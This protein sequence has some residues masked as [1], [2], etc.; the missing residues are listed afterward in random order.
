[1][2]LKSEMSSVVHALAAATATRRHAVAHINH[3]TAQMLAEATVSRHRQA[4]TQRHLRAQAMKAN[5]AETH[6]LLADAAAG[7]KAFHTARIP[8]SVE[9]NRGLAADRKALATSTAKWLKST[10]S[11]RGRAAAQN[12]KERHASRV[13]LGAD[14]KSLKKRFNVLLG[15]LT[16]DRVE[17]SLVW[18]K[19]VA[20]AATAAAKPVNVAADAATAAAAKHEAEVAAR[21]AGEV[22]A[23][24]AAQA[25]RDADA[26]AAAAQPKPAMQPN[27]GPKA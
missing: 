24:A 10:T 4:K 16:K 20:A 27:Q 11:A 9:L 21:R 3:E 2:S 5:R 12:N 26:R 8:Q 15:A 23:A 25:K 7:V 13:A 22:Q 6:A 18:Q 19:H 17:A 14:V 1:M